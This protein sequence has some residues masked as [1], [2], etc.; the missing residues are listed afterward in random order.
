[1]AGAGM[2][3]GSIGEV[4]P[5]RSEGLRLD[6][7]MPMYGLSADWALAL[8]ASAAGATVTISAFYTG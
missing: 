1:M 6:L 4:A 2:R 5:D 3:Q 8:E 7:P